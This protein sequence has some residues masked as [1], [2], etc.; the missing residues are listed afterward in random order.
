[1]SGYVYR[2]IGHG[3]KLHVFNTN[4]FGALCGLGPWR[5]GNSVMPAPK[6]EDI[7]CKACLRRLRAEGDK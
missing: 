1:M 6:S 7:V 4:S 2:F 3:Q 5:G